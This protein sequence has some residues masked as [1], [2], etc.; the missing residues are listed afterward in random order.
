MR[1]I[2]KNGIPSLDSYIELYMGDDEYEDYKCNVEE[3]YTDEY[4]EYMSSTVSHDEEMYRSAAKEQTITNKNECEILSLDES[5]SEI[6][7]HI[8]VYYD[9]YRMPH[10]KINSAEWDYFFNNIYDVFKKKE[11]STIFFSSLSTYMRSVL[12]R[13]LIL[14][15][16]SLTIEVLLSFL[17]TL[18]DIVEYSTPENLSDEEIKKLKDK[19]LSDCKSVHKV[20]ASRKSKLVNMALYKK[21]K[22][23]K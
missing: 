13:V 2:N 3:F 20:V 4:K 16:E 15:C 11:I 1:L 23:L 22:T 6:S 18:A 21:G 12:A 8:D 7:R 14:R 9:A 19:I 17:D 5:V 10:M